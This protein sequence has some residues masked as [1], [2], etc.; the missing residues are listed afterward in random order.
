MIQESLVL[1]FES[2][3]ASAFNS[4]GECSKRGA[5][6]LSDV[7]LVSM[8]FKLDLGASAQWLDRNPSR[9]CI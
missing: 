7:E 6:E 4:A 3:K 2:Y 8:L 5:R 1:K 9:G